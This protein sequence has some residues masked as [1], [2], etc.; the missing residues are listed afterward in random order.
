MEMEG[1]RRLTHID[2][3][4]SLWVPG[5]PMPILALVPA[6]SYVLMIVGRSGKSGRHGTAINLKWTHM[7][8]Y[9][10]SYTITQHRCCKLQPT[11]QE[12][13]TKICME[14]SHYR[15][16]RLVVLSMPAAIKQCILDVPIGL[17]HLV[18]SFPSNNPLLFA[19]SRPIPPQPLG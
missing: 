19:Q 15:S 4:S 13:V 1:Q 12:G 5:I 14:T 10:M 11:V 18:S 6:N 9:Y 17:R 16:E 8:I 2:Q 3:R 7:M